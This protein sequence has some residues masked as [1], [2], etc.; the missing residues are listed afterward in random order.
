MDEGDGWA[1]EGAQAE[2]NVGLTA[3]RVLRRRERVVELAAGDE[4]GGCGYL[5]AAGASPAVEWR[6]DGL[7]DD[8]AKGEKERGRPGSV[9]KSP[10][11]LCCWCRYCVY[12][13]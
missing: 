8:E 3:E 2:A 13:D 9:L 4:T 6:K 1:S 12:H 5:N 11:D 7:C 10:M